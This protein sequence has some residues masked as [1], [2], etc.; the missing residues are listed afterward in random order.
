ML[1]WPVEL[2]P[3]RFLL[4][5]GQHACRKNACEDHEHHVAADPAEWLEHVVNLVRKA[6]RAHETRIGSRSAFH[7]VK[8]EGPTSSSGWHVTPIGWASLRCRLTRVKGQVACKAKVSNVEKVHV[9]ASIS[10]FFKC[11]VPP[12]SPF[13]AAQARY[14]PVEC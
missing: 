8:S 4:G 13:F 2:E 7:D 11:I 9:Y 14:I 12:R 5:R 10:S 3:G 1:V 6:C